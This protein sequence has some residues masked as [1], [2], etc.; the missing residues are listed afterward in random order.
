MHRFK[1]GL[2]ALARLTR[3]FGGAALLAATGSAV[4][5]ATITS[6]DALV[7]VTVTGQ[8]VEATQNNP[9]VSQ[10][11]IDFANPGQ[12]AYTATIVVNDA[13][14]LSTAPIWP[15]GLYGGT[16]FG[17]PNPVT[18]FSISVDN[19]AFATSFDPALYSSAVSYFY[20]S[21]AA[22]EYYGFQGPQTSGTPFNSFDLVL[23]TS[24]GFPIPPSPFAAYS[25]PA[26]NAGDFRALYFETG[27]Y[28]SNYTHVWGTIDTI[29]ISI[30]ASATAPSVAPVPDPPP[31]R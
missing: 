28:Q 9:G 11:Y 4:T 29:D 31:G 7:V 12:S 2:F 22:T 19:G 14:G 26:A 1:V 27:F 16:Q 15:V 18:S 13:L 25:G 20:N 3:V 23:K 21:W 30:S 10:Q 6:A 5:L 8:I 17:L 24:D